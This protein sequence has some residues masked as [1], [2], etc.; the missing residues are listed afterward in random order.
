[1]GVQVSLSMLSA[2]HGRAL[3]VALVAQR[4]GHDGEQAV[5]EPLLGVQTLT[6]TVAHSDVF[7]P[8]LSI[9]TPLGAPLGVPR[10]RGWHCPPHLIS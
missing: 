9:H 6:G 1:M 5:E 4:N 10:G 8:L 3:R 7:A 2:E